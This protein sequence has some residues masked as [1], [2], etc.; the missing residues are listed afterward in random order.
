MDLTDSGSSVAVT[1]VKGRLFETLGIGPALGRAFR[2]GEDWRGEAR[3][4]V[5]SHRFWKRQ[6]GADPAA[7]DRSVRLDGEPYR[8]VG[9]MLRTSRWS[10]CRSRSRRR[11][12]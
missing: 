3:V 11:R 5:A 8:V 7:L 9:V 6:L 4:A 1:W 12:R 10:T 2:D